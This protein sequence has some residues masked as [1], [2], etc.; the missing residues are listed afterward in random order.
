MLG[1]C[2]HLLPVSASE[3]NT[4]AEVLHEMYLERDQTVV[5][6]RRKFM[7]LTQAMGPTENPNCPPSV[8]RAKQIKRMSVEKTE[9][10]LSGGS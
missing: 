9:E 10:V 2:E 3:W 7:Y 5:S 1:N 8:V 6:V 4:V